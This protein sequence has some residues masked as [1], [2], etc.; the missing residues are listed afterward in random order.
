V[1]FLHFAFLFCFH[2]YLW[3]F[4]EFHFDLYVLFLDLY[5]FIAIFV[6]S[7]GII[8]HIDNLSQSTHAPLN[9]PLNFLIRNL[10]ILDISSTYI[11][12]HVRQCYKF[13]LNQQMQFR[14]LKMRK[15]IFRSLCIASFFPNFQDSFFNHCLSV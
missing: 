12:N 7:P 4:L 3:V 11:G 1:F 14:K 10:I 9:V 6:V 15:S 5:H 2:A 13:S 8:L